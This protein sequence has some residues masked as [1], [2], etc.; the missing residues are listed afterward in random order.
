MNYSG[1]WSKKLKSANFNKRRGGAWM[2]YG[3]AWSKNLNLLTLI[4]E[5]RVREWT[6]VIQ[7]EKT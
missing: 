7:E 1:A 2:N 3:G 5:E 4:K 6:M